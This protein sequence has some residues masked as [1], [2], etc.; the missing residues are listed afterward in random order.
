MA[1]LPKTPWRLSGEEVASC[2]CAWGCPCQFNAHPTRGFCEAVIGYQIHTGVYGDVPLDGLRFVL[3]ARWPGALHEG[4]GV[5]Q[6]IIDERAS[7]SQRQALM[8]ILSGAEGGLYFEILAAVSSRTLET[9]FAPITVTADGDRRLARIHVPGLVEADL[10]PIRNP[11]TGAEHRARIVLPEGFEY[12]EAEMA[13]TVRWAV[14]APTA[15]AMGYE[16]TYGQI[17]AFDWRNT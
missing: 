11:V 2:S 6:W 10:E 1:S 12:H 16:N 9:V 17:N 13:N 3:I 15:L 4:N 14:Q 8:A 5:R 7:A